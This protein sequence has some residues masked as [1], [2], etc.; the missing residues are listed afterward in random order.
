MDEILNDFKARVMTPSEVN[1]TWE[2]FDSF[3]KEYQIGALRTS[4][5]IVEVDFSI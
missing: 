4:D 3:D 1:D 2:L 5:K